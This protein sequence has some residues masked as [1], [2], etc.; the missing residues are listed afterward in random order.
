MIN[1]A[2]SGNEH[3]PMQPPSIQNG[4]ASVIPPMAGSQ[5]PEATDTLKNQQCM[6]PGGPPPGLPG[7]PPPGLP[8]LPQGPHQMDKMSPLNSNVSGKLYQ[9]LASRPLGAIWESPTV[10]AHSGTPRQTSCPVPVLNPQ[11]VQDRASNASPDRRG[12]SRT[13]GSHPSA[14]EGANRHPSAVEGVNRQPV[15]N[16]ETNGEA[17][18]C[19]P[20]KDNKSEHSSDSHRGYEHEHRR[21]STLERR[22]SLHERRDS[23]ADRREG[24]FERRDSVHERRGDNSHESRSNYDHL[25]QR[26][27]ID[28]S[29]DRSDTPVVPPVVTAADRDGKMSP[30]RHSREYFGPRPDLV[31][32]DRYSMSA[33]SRD[34]HATGFHRH[35]RDN[36]C[37]GQQRQSSSDYNSG[38]SR[39]DMESDSRNHTSNNL[40]HHRSRYTYPPDCSCHGCRKTEHSGSGSSGSG[41]YSSTCEKYSSS[42]DIKPN[43]SEQLVGMLPSVKQS[44]NSVSINIFY[45]LERCCSGISLKRTPLG[46]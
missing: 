4:C 43:S 20:S 30:P 24:T 26:S 13:Q 11:D 7:G 9:D 44:S 19:C 8:V 6:T 29:S 34:Y 22:D 15:V 41:Y 42:K 25:R 35:E 5:Y 33:P 46:P 27:S 37:S 2:V 3:A 39:G 31:R 1:K 21:E 40:N 18:P 38:Y 23:N 10:G 17:C 28:H 16:G 14:M 36:S 45:V 32:Q 12:D